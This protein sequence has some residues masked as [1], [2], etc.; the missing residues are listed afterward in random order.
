MNEEL[1]IIIKA[2][3]SDAQKQLKKVK[4]ELGNIG[5]ETKKSSNTISQSFK[6]T[7]KTTAI[8]G[9]AIGSALV[10]VG[11]ALKKI[12][13]STRDYRNEQAKLNTA[14]KVVGAS[15]KT[16]EKTYNGLFRFM[17]ESD[18]AVETANHLAK[19]TN[20]Q[21]ALAEWTKICQGIYATFGDSLP[22]EGL[23]EAS[24]ETARVGKVTG[25]LADALNWAG[26][27][28]DSFNVSL[29]Q[30]T[31]LAEREALIR[32]TLNGLY[33][34]ASEEFEKSNKA[35]IE[36]N[37]SQ[38]KLDKALAN[39]GKVITPVLTAFNNLSASLLTML[40]PAIEHISN[41]IG[42]LTQKFSEALG[43]V[44]K[45]FGALSGKSSVEET[46]SNTA[47]GTKQIASGFDSATKSAEKFKRTTAGFDEL[48]KVGALPTSAS[49]GSS[50]P[51]GG[52]ITSGN[53]EVPPPDTTAFDNTIKKIKKE[54]DS[55][56]T[57][58]NPTVTAWKDAFNNIKE[59]WGEA[60]EHFKNGL[61]EIGAGF[62]DVG[63]YIKNTFIPDVVNSFSTNLAPMLSDVWGAII[64]E[65]AL[66]F[67]SFGGTMNSVLTDIII[68]S[69]DEFK[70]RFNG[71]LD[72]VKQAWEKHGNEF[73]KEFHK[74]GENFRGMW[75]T[76]YNKLILPIVQT[77]QKYS[78]EIW[79][80]YLKPLWD[81]ICDAALDIGTNLMILY[82]EVIAPIVNW[83]QENVYP[84]IVRIVDRIGGNVKKAIGQIT[85]VIQGVI[86]TL[87]GLIQFITGIFTGD[88]EKAWNG[89]KNIFG[90]IFDSLY[91]VVKVPLNH[92]INALNTMLSGLTKG[93]NAAIRVINKLSFTVP[94]WVPEI[95]GEKFGFNLKEVTAPKIPKLAKGGIIN[96]ATLIEAGE[97]GKEAIV[98]LENNVEWMDAFIDRLVA[99]QKTPSKIVLAVDGKELGWAT[100]DSI[101]GITKQT[102]ELQLE[103]A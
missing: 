82:N 85:E 78:S 62:S 42:Y 77:V 75:E 38:A 3:T 24:N 86:R 8:A 22:I 6:S 57:A 41:L 5:A 30:C 46:V 72:G 50:Q 39:I 87:K 14:F 61:S 96:S 16:A 64:E 4:T 59:S 37:E 10:G 98:P 95:G 26:V 81:D 102:G 9:A 18:R 49:G 55:L 73:L 67:E 103:F 28:E 99:R 53:T 1:K 84:V 19:L 94:D 63:S 31:T 23:T 89:V 56:K 48:N 71:I 25:V 43:W 44:N 68:P 74:V 97:A 17:G 65:T 79:D 93:V 51:T 90:G 12:E 80:E 2:V 88:W 40:S 70:K 32:G 35:I 92:I 76:F 52:V 69:M 58:F 20:N 60:K 54:I 101:N 34:Q 29:A 15:A 11:V 27:N 47:V 21:K 36:H 100:I 7:A 83:I 66:G 91:A 33:K 45:F 13:N